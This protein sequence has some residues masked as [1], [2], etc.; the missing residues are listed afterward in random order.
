MVVAGKEG[1]PNQASSLMK[2]KGIG[3]YTAGAIASIAFNEVSQF[4]FF[5]VINV[6]HLSNYLYVFW[7]LYCSRQYLLLMET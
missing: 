3:E 7:H 1:F 6:R 5:S 2:V 4:F